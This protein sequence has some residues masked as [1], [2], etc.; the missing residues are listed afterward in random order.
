MAFRGW[1]AEALEFYD[2]LTADNSKAYWTAHKDVYEQVVRA[3]MVELLAELEAEFGA[4]KI[5]RPNRDVRFSADKSPYKTAIGA[6]LDG[7]GYVQLSARGLA[8]GNGMYMMAPDQL[9]RYRHAVAQDH[10][11][12]PLEAIIAEVKRHRIDVEGHDQLKTAPRGYPKDHPRVDLLRCKGLIAWKQWP[13][14]AWLGTAAAKSR[15]VDFLHAAQ[16]LHA[17]LAEYV[18]ET[19][20]DAQR[21]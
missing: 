12:K 5:F 17:W 19:T 4:A 11:G 8:A 3:P 18:G 16:P 13:V 15:V 20:L 2:G 14:A 9:E 6:S 10:T 21:R 1:P 7:G